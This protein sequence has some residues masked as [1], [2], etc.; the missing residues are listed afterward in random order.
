MHAQAVI[1]TGFGDGY[2]YGHMYGNSSGGNV[3]GM[4]SKRSWVHTTYNY[5]HIR[6]H[7]AQLWPLPKPGTFDSARVV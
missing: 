3:S 4:P 6:G 7:F 1:N 5:Q 2:G